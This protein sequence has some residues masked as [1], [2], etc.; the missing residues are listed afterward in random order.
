MICPLEPC[1]C[2]EMLSSK[3]LFFLLNTGNLNSFL[4]L[5]LLLIMFFPLS[6]VFQILLP[7]FQLNFL[8][9]L[10]LLIL[11]CLLMNSQILFTL[12]WI[13]LNLLLLLNMNLPLNL[14]YLLF[15]LA[16]LLFESPLGLI[17]LLL[18]FM[19]TTAVQL[20]LITAT[21]LPF[22]YLPMI[23]S[24]LT[25]QVSFIHF[26]QLSLILSCLM[27]IEPSLWPCLLPRNPLSMLKLYLIHCG[28]LP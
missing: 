6:P 9:P 24:Q 20:P 25:V 23:Q 22:L 7:L 1:L 5:L 3:R 10:V 21:W 8:F 19:P 14:I 26:P 12:I 17:K 18:I 27:H 16:Y 2:P 15:N 4:A 28:K 13:L 11:L